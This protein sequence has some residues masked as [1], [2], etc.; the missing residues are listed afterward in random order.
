MKEKEK[1]P[2]AHRPIIFLWR[3]CP[4]IPLAQKIEIDSKAESLHINLSKGLINT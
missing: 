1:E 2:K 4:S 3:N